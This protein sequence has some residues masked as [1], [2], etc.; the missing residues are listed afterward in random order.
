MTLLVALM[1][2]DASKRFSIMALLLFCSSALLS[3]NAM[4]ILVI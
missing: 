3:E 4:Q 1:L 2:Y